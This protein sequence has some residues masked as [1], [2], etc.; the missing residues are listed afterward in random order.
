[1]PYKDPEKRRAVQR[2]YMARQRATPEGR[3]RLLAIA[4]KSFEKHKTKYIPVRK[5]WRLKN[6][7]RLQTRESSRV[8]DPEKIRASQ[9]AY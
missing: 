9:A 1:M 4:A 3:A 7:E 6:K 5:A 2:K 8:R